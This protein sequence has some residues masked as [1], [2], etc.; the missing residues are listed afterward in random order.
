MDKKNML[1]E[2]PKI[3]ELMKR[4]ELMLFFQEVDRELIKEGTREIIQEV[5]NEIIKGNYSKET[6]DEREIIGKIIDK[7]NIKS[8]YNLRKAINGTGVVLHTNLGR[9]KLSKSAVKAVTNAAMDYSNLEYDI[10]SGQRGSRHDHIEKI[11]KKITGTEAA[12]AVNNNAAATMLS[13]SAI[14][15]G[16]EVIV[17]R[18][19]LV[20]I[21][22]SFRIPEI[23][24]QSGCVLKE[25]GTTNKTNIND[26]REAITEE[27]G[28]ILKVHTSNYK[29]LGFTQ[30]VSLR[31]LVEIGK[32]KSIPVIYDM[33]SGLMVN[34]NEYGID[35]PT[36]K[37]CL[38]TEIDI[39]LFSG[40]KLLG[41]PQGGIIAGKKKYIEL[42][43][44]H[45]LARVVRMDKMSIAALEATFREY[46][47]E[48]KAINEVPTL[49]MLTV[50]KEELEARG[51]KFLKSLKNCNKNLDF[52]IEETFNQVGGGTAPMVMLNGVGISITSKKIRAD[53]LEQRLRENEIPIIGRIQKDRLYIE[54]RTISKEEELI[55]KEAITNIDETLE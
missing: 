44:K 24:K 32:E 51:R 29:I 30:E 34:L 39:I 12:M 17:S 41:G 28:A 14:G 45:Q 46:L 36:V 47:S 22:G 20:E 37:E 40:D 18:G 42:M 33:G 6:I 15:S 4:E 2:I 1:R 35:E 27:T 8:K 43:K 5:R 49:R 13:L 11:I 31:E 52:A 16:K 26:Y 48:E 38:A 19:E 3:D 9:A 54:M 10:E 23:M 7:I 25:V 21:G 55:I 50:S 53:L